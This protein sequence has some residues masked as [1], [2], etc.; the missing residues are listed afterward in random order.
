M[1]AALALL[2]LWQYGTKT[3]RISPTDQPAPYWVIVHDGDKPSARSFPNHNE[4]VAH[5][6][7]ELLRATLNHQSAPSDA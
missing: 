1:A 3:C 6:V 5:A 2:Q 7:D 4:A